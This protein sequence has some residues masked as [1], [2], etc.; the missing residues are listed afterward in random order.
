[1]FG[2]RSIGGRRARK[3]GKEKM[4][5]GQALKGG[6]FWID[7]VERKG[8]E[9]AWSQGTAVRGTVRGLAVEVE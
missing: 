2:V 5:L 9:G 4:E 7:G 8:Q 3:G 6:G 1:M